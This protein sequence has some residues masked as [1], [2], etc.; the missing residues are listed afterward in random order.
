MTL[1]TCS[2]CAGVVTGASKTEPLSAP[3]GARH[4]GRSE[5]RTE[6]LLKL[7]INPLPTGRHRL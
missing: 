2:L 7:R 1:V 3:V 5:R 4:A 6:A